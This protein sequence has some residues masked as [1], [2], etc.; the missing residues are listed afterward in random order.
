MGEPTMAEP[1]KI[2]K[3]PLTEVEEVALP[4]TETEDRGFQLLKIGTPQEFEAALAKVENALKLIDKLRGFCIARTRANDWLNQSGNPYLTESGT[5]RFAAPFQIYEEEVTA[6]SVD[7]Q[8]IKR[9]IGEKQMFQGN[10]RFFFFRGI[11]GS[12]VLGIE[13]S[14]EGGSSLEEGFQDK[15]D[16]LFYFQKAKANWRGRG[17]RK[18]LGLETVTWDEILKLANIKQSDIRSVDRISTAK[19]ETDEMKKCWDLLLELGDGDAKKAEDILFTITDSEKFPGKKR[20][21]QLSAKQ[22][23]WV[24]PK[25]E[26]EHK[27]RFGQ[28]EQVD[29]TTEKDQFLAYVNAVTPKLDE[30]M[31][32]SLLKQVGAARIETVPSE[33]RQEFYKEYKRLSELQSHLVKND[34][35]RKPQ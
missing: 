18:L 25:V 32:K 13:A 26:R 22:M 11:I 20:P 28:K 16:L 17:F 15:D 34:K 8:G 35:E 23:A 5:N 7:D 9:D 21:S 2:E 4:A 3:L 27:L 6:W 33:K 24:L 30:P 1:E 10:I 29:E 31:L 14:F 12:K 19:A